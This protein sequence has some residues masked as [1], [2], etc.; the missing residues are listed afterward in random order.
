MFIS[1]NDISYILGEFGE[2]TYVLPLQSNIDGALDRF[3]ID[4]SSGEIFVGLNGDA[5]LDYETKTSYQLTI[6]AI[7]NYREGTLCKI[8][9]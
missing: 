5:I 1:L 7:D 2:V 4:Q 3:I 8:Y 9:F 6:N